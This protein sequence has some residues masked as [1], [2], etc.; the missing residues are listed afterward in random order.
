MKKKLLAGLATGLFLV[1]MVGMA[2]AAPTKW[3]SEIDGNDHWYDIISGSSV[4]WTAANTAAT[5]ATYS[6]MQ[7]Y[8]ASITSDEENEFV[9]SLFTSSDWVYN[10]T[11]GFMGPWIGGYQPDGSTWTWTSGEVWN[12]TAW[13]SNQPSN[14][15]NQDYVHY[16]IKLA[17]SGNPLNED[18]TWND[19]QD[20]ANG[21]VYGYVVEYNPVP[22][23]A[24]LLLLGS[25]LAGIAGT[26]IRRKKA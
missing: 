18:P 9:A 23:P 14:Q 19:H 24:T 26:R 17:G 20:E 10:N 2:S 15:P 11:N 8:L 6:G 13:E 7:G 12:Y 1:G 25:G 16:Y 21:K 4:T 5:G 22:I 3:S